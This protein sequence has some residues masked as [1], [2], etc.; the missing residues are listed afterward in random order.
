MAVI[1][2][3]KIIDAHVHIFEHMTGIKNCEPNVSLAY[4]KIKTG[5]EV[6]QFFIP[7]FERSDS[8]T[9]MLLAYMDCYGVEKAVL[10]PNIF[11]GYHNEYQAKAVA[12]HP[13][14]FRTF[15]LVDVMKG[16]AAARELENMLKSGPYI[17]LKIEAES[18]FQFKP[19]MSLDD[20][21][22]Y[23]VW[24]VLNGMKSSLMFHLYRA[25]DIRAL[26]KL[27]PEHR[28][29]KFFFCHCGAEAAFGNPGSL[30]ERECLTD[31]VRDNDNA[32]YEVSTT[33]AY[34]AGE[35]YPFVE[36]SAYIQSMYDI[37]GAEKLLW[38]SDYPGML[39]RGNYDRLIDYVLVDCPNIPRDDK[40]KIMYGNSQRLFFD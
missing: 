7:A 9:D 2:G 19:D 16:E 35:S 40:E 31:M 26:K 23:P 32:W 10:L 27:I 15:A 34:L 36:G 18:A 30:A 28:G 38:G 17:G 21:F 4:G 33:P 3:M 8:G 5:N 11:Y 24:D 22:L 6:S 37:L 12:E 20:G 1:E 13:D 25:D 39:M 29:I 14:R